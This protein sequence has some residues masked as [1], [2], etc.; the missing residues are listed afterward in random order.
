MCSVTAILVVVTSV[1]AC[2]TCNE[3][4][5]E[6]GEDSFSCQEDHRYTVVG[7]AL[8][9]NVAALRALWLAIRAL[10]DDAASLSYMASHYGDDFGMSADARR[11]EAAAALDAAER[12]RS[13]ARRAQDRLDALPSAPSAVR[14]TG[15]G[16]GRGW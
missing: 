3:V 2:P 15:S 9:T 4:L 12:L 1:L 7:L 14:V 6:R 8:T 10:E 11:A 13:H 5:L 16:P